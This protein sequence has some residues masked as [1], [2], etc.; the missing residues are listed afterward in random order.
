MDP[1]F[2]LPLSC[3]SEFGVQKKKKNTAITEEEVGAGDVQE[4][5]LS[6]SFTSPA[7]LSKKDKTV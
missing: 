3:I 4:S 7:S 6:R 2:T 1:F 5:L